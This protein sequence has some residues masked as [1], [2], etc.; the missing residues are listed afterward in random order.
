MAVKYWVGGAGTWDASTNW[1]TSSGGSRN[2][3]PPGTSD[4]AVFDANSGSGTV[5]INTSTYVYCG[6]LKVTADC[7]IFLSGSAGGSNYGILVYLDS[8]SATS[9]GGYGVDIGRSVSSINI[10]IYKG[11]SGAG[12][13]YFNCTSALRN[14]SFNGNL[15]GVT[16]YLSSDITTQFDFNVNATSTGNFNFYSSGYTISS[17]GG[18]SLGFSWSV[19]GI[20]NLTNSSLSTSGVI[21]FYPQNG[22]VFTLSNNS[23]TSS[24]NTVQ[25]FSASGGV[26][27]A[28]NISCNTASL[29]LSAGSFSGTN[30][31]YVSGGA[32]VYNSVSV[33]GT[34]TIYKNS[35]TTQNFQVFTPGISIAAANSGDLSLEAT[36]TISSITLSSSYLTNLFLASDVTV[37]SL[38][39]N[40]L[41][42]SQKTV[43][44][45]S[46]PA[47]I[48]TAS[49]FS[50]SY[51]NWKDITAAGTIPFTGT[52]FVD[53][54][55]NTN[56]QFYVH[57][58]SLFFAPNF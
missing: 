31:F 4:L 18:G 49:S 42:G 33:S 44:S 50:L 28:S 25:T 12:T 20:C 13:Y 43:K 58:Q 36:A 37:N 14:F 39:V 17:F 2:T 35:S 41:S 40:G 10:G 51:I 27:N 46:L 22:A 45:Y 47:K 1:S 30:S 24:S 6:S 55:G 9:N 3:S 19:G 56:I 5:Q 34:F 15:S 16:A 7:N 57:R 23:I 48:L 54:G 38:S 8:T 53:Q 26:I 11:T 32:T 21:T 52:G 29:T